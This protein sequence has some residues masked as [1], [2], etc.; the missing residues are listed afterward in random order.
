MLTPSRIQEA[1]KKLLTAKFA[2]ITIYEDYTPADFAR[3]S[4]L[5]QLQSIDRR[6]VNCK[7]I[8]EKCTISITGQLELD[9]YGI[10]NVENRLEILQGICGIFLAGTIAVDDRAVKCS[11]QASANLD[12]IQVT[13]VAIYWEERS[14]AQPQTMITNVMIKQKEAT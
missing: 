13:V 6:N 7:T 3:P 10:S 14:E 4:L 11:V 8:E 9:E 2:G 1:I 5:L 12:E